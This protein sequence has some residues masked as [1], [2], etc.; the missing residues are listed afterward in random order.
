MQ[1]IFTI[2][3]VILQVRYVMRH[4]LEFTRIMFTQK[5]EYTSPHEMNAVIP[6][7]LEIA[8]RDKQKRLRWN[9][10]VYHVFATCPIYQYQVFF[11]IVEFDIIFRLERRTQ[12]RNRHTI[13][14]HY[15]YLVPFAQKKIIV[16]TFKQMPGY[17]Y[18][19][20]I[21]QYDVVFW[22]FIKSSCHV[23]KGVYARVHE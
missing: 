1:R 9:I 15:S 12:R 7:R 8:V 5:P 23:S 20:R 16:E 11:D 13:E 2:Y 6:C 4:P 18:D 17:L 14:Q 10:D 19:R 21:R 3:P 22:Y